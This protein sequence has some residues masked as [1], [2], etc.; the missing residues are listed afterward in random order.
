VG[1]LHK[2][3]VVDHEVE[4]SFFCRAV[5]LAF[6]DKASLGIAQDHFQSGQLYHISGEKISVNEKIPRNFY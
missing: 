3:T 2:S 4:V 1:L 6:L 5:S